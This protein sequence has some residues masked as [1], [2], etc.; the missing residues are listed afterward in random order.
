MN[1]RA[2]HRADAEVVAALEAEAAHH[3]WTLEQVTGSLSNDAGCGWVI[4]DDD[5]PIGHLLGSVVLDEAELGTLAVLPRARRRGVATKL[6][7][8]AYAGWRAAGATLAFLE[9]R[10]DNTGALRL[11]EAEGWTVVG[12]RRGYYGD[13]CD[14]LLMR[15]PLTP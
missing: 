13:G 1:V 8:A 6:L 14:A 15:R 7:Q 5:G 12:R 3:P 10:V 2:V 11:Y 9:V 4:E